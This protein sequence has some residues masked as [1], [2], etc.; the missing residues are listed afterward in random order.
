MG[1]TDA[2]IL[3][4]AAQLYATIIVQHLHIGFYFDCIAGLANPAPQ[5]NYCT[6]NPWK[7]KCHVLVTFHVYL[8]MHNA[9]NNKL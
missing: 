2:V 6:I 1:S 3:A 7:L 8:L 4:N 9:L 5:C